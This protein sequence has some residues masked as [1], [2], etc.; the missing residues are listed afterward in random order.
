M[1]AIKTPANFSNCNYCSFLN[2]IYEANSNV[3]DAFLLMFPDERTCDVLK[4]RNLVTFTYYAFE[5]IAMTQ[6]YT[7]KGESLIEI[8]ICDCW[9]LIASV[10]VINFETAI[11]G[12]IFQGRGKSTSWCITLWLKLFNYLYIEVIYFV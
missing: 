7:I 6:F 2:I 12:S 1:W 10:T 11:N 3:N 4:C 5:E 8:S 9:R